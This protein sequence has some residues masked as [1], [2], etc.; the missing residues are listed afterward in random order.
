MS[1]RDNPLKTY[2]SDAEDQALDDI[3]DK[4]G[5]NRASFCRLAVMNFMIEQDLKV[6]RL[7]EITGRYTVGRKRVA[8]GPS[9]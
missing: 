4:L 9:E 7:E 8:D 5:M 1:E 2:L 3:I 6:S